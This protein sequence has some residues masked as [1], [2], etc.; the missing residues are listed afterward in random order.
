MIII[1]RIREIEINSINKFFEEKK[2]YK[3]IKNKKQNILFTK[4]S[5]WYISVII[6]NTKF[7]LH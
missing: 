4:F 2:C 5:K 6:N 3:N 1:I 7:I